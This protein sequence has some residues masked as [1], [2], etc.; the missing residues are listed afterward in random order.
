M[1][2]FI[3]SVLVTDPELVKC[4][5]VRNF[6][7]F[8]DRG[9]FADTESDPISGSLFSLEGSHW[10]AMRQ[11]LSP[12]FTS[13]KMKHMFGLMVDVAEQIYGHELPSS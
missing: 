2:F 3:P 7:V 10:R 12:A 5:L 8:H 4:V 13:G 1:N 9:L 11:K 6:D